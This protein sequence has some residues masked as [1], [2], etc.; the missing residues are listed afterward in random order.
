MARTKKQD[1]TPVEAILGITPAQAQE[2]LDTLTERESQVVELMANGTRNKLIAEELGIS[3]KTLD[4]H[5]GNVQRKLRV[6]T[7]VDVARY[8][9]ATKFG[10][11][12]E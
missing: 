5:R 8:V 6:K 10:K 3:I 7:A 9:F 1:L 2:A 11:L 4:I 12:F